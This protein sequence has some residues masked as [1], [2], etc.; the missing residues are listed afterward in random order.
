M[1]NGIKK[2]NK[3]L[4]D[5]RDKYQIKS[6]RHLAQLMEITPS[7]ISRVRSGRIPFGPAYT[8]VV[9]EVFDIPIKQIKERIGAA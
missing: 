7:N 2:I 8:L 6:D 1:E 4:D 9:H 3:F 5:L